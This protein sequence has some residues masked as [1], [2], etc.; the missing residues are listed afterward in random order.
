M[1]LFNLVVQSYLL[2]L[3]FTVTPAVQAASGAQKVN[4][5]RSCGNISVPFPFGLEEG[6]S[7]RKE[8]QLKCTNET[9]P[10][11][12]FDAGHQVTHIDIDEGIVGITYTPQQI[13]RVEAPKQSGMYIGSLASSSVQWVF[14]N[15]TCQEAQQ[16]SSAYG[17]IH[18]Y[19]ACLGVTSADGNIGYRC[20]CALGFEGN[21]YI[22]HGCLDIDECDEP[23][24][25]QGLCHNT[26]GSYM[27]TSCPHGT[28]FDAVKRRCTPINESKNFLTGR[29]SQYLNYLPISWTPSDPATLLQVSAL[30]QS[31]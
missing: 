28:V 9:S 2:L 8:F 1:R 16:N 5:L 11:L 17:C 29:S 3:V 24:M 6:C 22:P 31:C 4:C 10:S 26:L 19:S 30:P 18:H 15:L 13:F 14:A 7:A 25:C 21:P 12:Q 20:K 27:C 23:N